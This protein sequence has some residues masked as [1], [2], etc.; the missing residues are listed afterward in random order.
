M[1]AFQYYIPIYMHAHTPTLTTRH[2]FFKNSFFPPTIIEWNKLDR[3]V[4]N[5]TSFNI[6]RKGILK[7]VRP[8]ANSLFNCHYPKG[9]NSITGLRLGLSHFKPIL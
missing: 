2:T 6:S 3:G 7:F 9:I 8:S 4:R 1:K 5:S